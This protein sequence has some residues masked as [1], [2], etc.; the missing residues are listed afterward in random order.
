MTICFLN[1]GYPVVLIFIGLVIIFG[2]ILRRILLKRVKNDQFRWVVIILLAVLL[3]TIIL[4]AVMGLI[5]WSADRAE[6]HK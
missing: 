2:I 6:W 1:I 5:L 4:S 3:A